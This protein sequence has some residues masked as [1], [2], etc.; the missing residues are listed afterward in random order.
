[1]SQT[2]HFVCQ[3][4]NYFADVTVIVVPELLMSLMLVTTEHVVNELE[5]SV[6]LRNLSVFLITLFLSTISLLC[7][8]ASLHYE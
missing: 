4:A 3:T 6:Y 8:F 1:M 5:F 7:F 2:T